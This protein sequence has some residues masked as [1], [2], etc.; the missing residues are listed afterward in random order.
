M[1]RHSH[2]QRF[3]DSKNAQAYGTYSPGRASRLAEADAFAP[4]NSKATTQTAHPQAAGLKIGQPP[5]KALLPTA[6]LRRRFIAL[7]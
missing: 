4:L 2:G 5:K 1:E 3:K 6:R 7:R